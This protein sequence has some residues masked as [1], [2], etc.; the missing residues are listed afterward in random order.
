MPD[1]RRLAEHEELLTSIHDDLA[2]V[3]A[4]IAA[5]RPLIGQ[6]PLGA[7]FHNTRGSG[8]ASAYAAVLAGVTRLDASVGGLGGCPFAAHAGAAGNIC[9]EDFVLMCEEMGI[10]TGVDL[11]ALAECARLAERIV[12][13]PLPG[14]VKTGGG[15]NAMRRTLSAS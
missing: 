3:T 13:H 8:L 5:V 9:T 10:E 12:G 7:H 15:L 11:E 1:P 14:K 4:L 2:A 6:L